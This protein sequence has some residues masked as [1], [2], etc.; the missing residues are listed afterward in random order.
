MSADVVKDE[1]DLHE[2]VYHTE[3]PILAWI[4]RRHRCRDVRFA[5]S[6]QAA[7][8]TISVVCVVIPMKLERQLASFACRAQ[9]DDGPLS[10]LV[11]ALCKHPIAKYL[12]FSVDSHRGGERRRTRFCQ[13]YVSAL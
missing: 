1:V 5:C 12:K 2:L 3:E 4:L 6:S 13:L 9:A 11:T 8:P 7:L 10:S